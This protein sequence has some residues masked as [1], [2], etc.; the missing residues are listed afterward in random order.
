[1]RYLFL[2]AESQ[3]LLINVAAILFNYSRSVPLRKGPAAVALRALLLLFC[4]C[5][6]EEKDEK[7][8]FNPQSALPM[9][10]CA[11]AAASSRPGFP[12]SAVARASICVLTGPKRE[13]RC[14]KSFAKLGFPFKAQQWDAAQLIGIN[15]LTCQGGAGITQPSMHHRPSD[16]AFF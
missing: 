14:C 12:D 7:M 11:A 4:C 6:P 13:P 15:A 3:L 2:Q 10:T 8:M 1:M 9:L 16:C 5:C